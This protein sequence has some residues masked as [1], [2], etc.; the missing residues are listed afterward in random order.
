M[1]KIILLAIAL[2]VLSLNVFSQND[3][4]KYTQ[5]LGF[6]FGMTTGTG[7]AYLYQPKNF[8]AQIVVGAYN[9]NINFAISPI[10]TLGH[11]KLINF[12]AYSGNEIFYGKKFWNQQKN[13][14]ISNGLGFGFEIHVK[15]FSINLMSG[16][17]SYYWL[18]GNWE[19]GS[20]FELSLFYKLK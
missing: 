9:N 18:N 20:T 7:L 19:Y 10:L 12:F 14:R 4:V 16:I 17:S 8:G 2:G 13:F 5:G 6:S 11:S 1:K 3:T 15:Q